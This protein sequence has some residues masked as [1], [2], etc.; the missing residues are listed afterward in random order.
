MKIA[1]D[2]HEFWSEELHCEKRPPKKT[3]MLE[4]YVLMDSTELG[5]TIFEIEI[6]KDNIKILR[7]IF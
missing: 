1:F 5:S 6:Q 2:L 3:L 4:N 7:L